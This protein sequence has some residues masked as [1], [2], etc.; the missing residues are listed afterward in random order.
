M[1][2]KIMKDSPAKV[3]GI[4]AS[5]MAIGLANQNYDGNSVYEQRGLRV[6]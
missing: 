3:D 4:M 5:I 6:L 2:K 1:I